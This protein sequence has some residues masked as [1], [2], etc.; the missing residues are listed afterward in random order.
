MYKKYEN[1]ICF[2]KYNKFKLFLKNKNYIIKVKDLISLNYKYYKLNKYY[3]YRKI[4]FIEIK[5]NL[6]S[7]FFNKIS[8]Y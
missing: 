7:F 6:K 2:N 1:F 5:Y 4:S 8:F 3:N